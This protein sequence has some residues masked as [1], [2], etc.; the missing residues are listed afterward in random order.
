VALSIT[1]DQPDGRGYLTAVPAD[2]AG[3]RTSALNYEANQSATTLAFVALSGGAAKFLTSRSAH[4]Q[5]DVLGWFSGV[6]PIDDPY[7]QFVPTAPSRLVD[8]RKPIGSPPLTAGTLRTI[9]AAEAGVPVSAIA[10][11]VNHAA[12]RSAGSGEVQTAA[13][14]KPQPP[15]FRNL[16]IG[17]PNQTRA[18]STITQL[19]DATYTFTSTVTAH[20]V[21]DLVGYFQG[22]TDPPLADGETTMVEGFRFAYNAYQNGGVTMSDGA[23]WFYRPTDGIL[24][25]RINGTTVDLTSN[26]PYSGRVSG[27]G[28]TVLHE[29]A[30]TDGYTGVAAYDPVT[31]IEE[32]IAVTSDEVSP[33]IGNTWVIGLSTD[34]RRVL[35]ASF[36][37][38]ANGAPGPTALGYFLRDRDAGTTTLLLVPA[39]AYSVGLTADGTALVWVQNVAPSQAQPYG[40]ARIT[41][42]L[43]AGA[44]GITREVPTLY[45]MVTYDG[46]ASL[47]LYRVME[48]AGYNLYRL[49]MAT[50][51]SARVTTVDGAAFPNSAGTTIT[52]WSNSR[53]YTTDLDG[54]VLDVVDRAWN[55]RAP[56]N[57]SSA[58]VVSSDGTRVVF[59]SEATNILQTATTGYHLYLH[60]STPT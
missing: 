27:D 2:F 5:I 53:V 45:P 51:V 56:N 38:L 55:G 26:Y 46:D 60:T 50:G 33:P 14:A 30:K 24:F 31:T 22:I 34:G 52:F 21:S 16:F 9:D 10:A 18:A 57:G 48:N 44:T 49:D 6:H 8:T 29:T 17:A 23:R 54:N 32:D 13:T 15:A 20:H 1:V 37:A 12:I 3:E 19:H 58:P 7:G 43:L 11:F 39:D 42:H 47:V 35:L 28:R 59:A 36:A 40:A 41:R 4:L 25:D